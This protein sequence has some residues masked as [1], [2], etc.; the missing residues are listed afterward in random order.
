[1]VGA[2]AIE[3][4]RR[5]FSAADAWDTVCS[6]LLA[7]LRTSGLDELSK[8]GN[9]DQLRSQAIL[10]AFATCLAGALALESLMRGDFPQESLSL[11]EGANHESGA[12]LAQMSITGNQALALLAGEVLVWY[13][14]NWQRL[15]KDVAT[16]WSSEFARSQYPSLKLGELDALSRRTERVLRRYG[17]DRVAG[18]FEQ[19]L[20]LL[21][22][23]MGCIVVQTR[24]FERSVDIVCLSESARATFLVEA[25]STARAYSLP[26]S[27]ERALAEY[28][29]TV[30]SGLGFLPPLQLILLV[31]PDPTKTLGPKLRQ[32]SIQLNVPVR[33]LRAADLARAR[34]RINGVFPLNNLLTRLK[35]ADEVVDE[36]LISMLA[37]DH[38]KE[39]RLI[40]DLVRLRLRQ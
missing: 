23:S 18:R 29:E 6:P 1:M 2:L 26:T 19:Q 28:V 10:A 38:E 8:E 14:E 40:L 39:L 7:V 34:L 3:C 11:V 31:G 30:R 9:E 32:L 5:L 25:K 13:H 16:P 27:D 17:R 22:S 35:E 24:R 36:A 21:A 15:Y 4:L 33:F 20:A 37:E 12:A